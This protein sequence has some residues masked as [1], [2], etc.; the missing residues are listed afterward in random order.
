MS[1]NPLDAPEVRNPATGRARRRPERAMAETAYS[2]KGNRD[3]L[4]DRGIQCVIPEKDD[5]KAN[6][7]REGSAGGRPVTCDKEACTCAA[8]SWSAASTP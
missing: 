2:S 8:T 3:Y 1:E 7:K 4:R 6:R 5:R